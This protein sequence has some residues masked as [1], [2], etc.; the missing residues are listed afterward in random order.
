MTQ[1]NGVSYYTV[2]VASLDVYFPEDH[3]TCNWCPYVQAQESLKRHKCL[4]TGEYLLYPF[5]GRGNN[6][7]VRMIENNKG[8]TVEWD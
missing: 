7:P 2:G 5:T 3:T 8:E 4:L 1:S 6:C